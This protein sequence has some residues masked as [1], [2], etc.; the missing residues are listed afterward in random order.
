MKFTKGKWFAEKL[1]NGSTDV[2]VDHDSNLIATIYFNKNQEIGEDEYNALLI[3]KAPELLE[4]VIMLLSLN[5]ALGVND[6]WIEVI[7]AKKLIKEA[8]EL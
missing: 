8:T 7:E 1:T 4:M 6:D 3:S 2:F 5:K